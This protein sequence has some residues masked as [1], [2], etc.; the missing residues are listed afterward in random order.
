MERDFKVG[1]V[2]IRTTYSGHEDAP[3]VVTRILDD[4]LDAGYRD[5]PMLEVLTTENYFLGHMLYPM[6]QFKKTGETMPEISTVIQKLN[7][8]R[9]E[10]NTDAFRKGR[11]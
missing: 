5:C 4:R 10:H 7:R 8:L 6:D 11:D 2:V 1:D 9:D 3:S